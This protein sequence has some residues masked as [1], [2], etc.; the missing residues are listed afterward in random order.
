MGVDEFRASGGA[1]LVKSCIRRRGACRPPFLNFYCFRNQSSATTN[2]RT[3][4]SNFNADLR[5]HNYCNVLPSS[6]WRATHIRPLVCVL[7]SATSRA[8][9]APAGCKR[10]KC[11][12]M[13]RRCGVGLKLFTCVASALPRAS[14]RCSQTESYSTA[15]RVSTYQTYSHN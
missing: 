15:F 9:L 5:P 11:L 10:A 8:V 12:T 13:F 1:C 6:G 3:R 2:A 4:N 14:H 7:T